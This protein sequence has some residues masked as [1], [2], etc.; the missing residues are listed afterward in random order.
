[1][2]EKKKFVL[3]FIKKHKICVLATITPDGHPEAGV[4]EFGETDNLELIFDTFK[5]YRKYK[6]LKNNPDVAV[7][8]GWDENVT[9]QY[10]GRAAELSGQELKKYQALYYAKNPDAEKWL[11]FPE[12]TFFKVIPQWLRYRD[13]NTDPMTIFEINNFN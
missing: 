8:I 12:V 5:T 10:E 11:K 6:N 9:I 3:D 1:M 7:V 4:I 2:D 13:G